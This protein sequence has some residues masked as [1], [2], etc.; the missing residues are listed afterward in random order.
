MYSRGIFVKKVS[1]P[2]FF[3]PWVSH[4]TKNVDDQLGIPSAV[5]ESQNSKWLPHERENGIKSSIMVIETHA[6]DQFYV[7][8]S[9]KIQF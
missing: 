9:Q 5:F 2:Y 3:L 7:S 8:S 1:Q 6:V 4:M